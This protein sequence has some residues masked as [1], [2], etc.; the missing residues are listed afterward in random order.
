M[1]SRVHV[2]TKWSGGEFL[3]RYWQCIS[4]LSH[5]LTFTLL[6]KTRFEVNERE[7]LNNIL[8]TPVTVVDNS[9]SLSKKVLETPEK[10]RYRKNI[11]IIDGEGG[12]NLM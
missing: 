4:D 7:E 2:V 1:T 5:P 11:K 6:D 8:D 12:N 9:L 10:V 3:H